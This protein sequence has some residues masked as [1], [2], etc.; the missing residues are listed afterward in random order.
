MKPGI[1]M[2][3]HPKMRASFTDNY[4]LITD[5]F[6]TSGSSASCVIIVQPFIMLHR[7]SGTTFTDHEPRTTDHGPRTTNHGPRTTDHGPRAT[8]HGPRTTGHGP[9]TTD[10]ESRIT[11]ITYVFI[12]TGHNVRKLKY[13]TK[14]VYF[15]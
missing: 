9:R 5:N 3:R 14:L 8:G 11:I 13:I 2:A 1:K 6:I 12:H 7:I 10:H 15:K 4:E